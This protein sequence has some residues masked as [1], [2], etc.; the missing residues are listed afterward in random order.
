MT[1]SNRERAELDPCDLC[2]GERKVVSRAH[3]ATRGQMMACPRCSGTGIEPGD[4]SKDPAKMKQ[5]D[6]FTARFEPKVTTDLREGAEAMIGHRLEWEIG[7][8]Q[9][10]GSYEGELTCIVLT[11]SKLEEKA[12]PFVWAPFC[13]LVAIK[14][15]ERIG[16]H[17]DRR[18]P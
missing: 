1:L 3:N 2:K 12:M 5:W 9:E 10:E 15:V 8:V 13:D 14:H 4:E 16:A 7:W 11:Y 18:K 17:D 6:R